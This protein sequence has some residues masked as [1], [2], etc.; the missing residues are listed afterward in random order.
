IFTSLIAMG[1]I[2]GVLLPT[3]MVV[4]LLLGV[5]VVNGVLL[6]VLLV[7]IIKLVND[8]DVMGEYRNGHIHNILAWAT[9]AAIGGLSILMV[10]TTVLPAVGLNLSL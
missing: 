9:V 5:Q 1:T 6:P 4:S 7:F 10:L 8:P 3:A 2:V